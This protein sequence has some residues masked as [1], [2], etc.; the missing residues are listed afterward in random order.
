MDIV[1]V[2]QTAQRPLIGIVGLVMIILVAM[3]SLKSLKSAAA[4]AEEV[5]PTIALPRTAPAGQAGYMPGAPTPV[6]LPTNT[7]RDRVN[8]TIE[9]QPEV[10]ARVVR[11]WLKD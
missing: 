2:I 11:A 8:S 10:A 9:Q 5:A 1:N 7:M 4:P 3:W 6:V